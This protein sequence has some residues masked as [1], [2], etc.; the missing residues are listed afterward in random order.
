MPVSAAPVPNSV[1]IDRIALVK[2]ALEERIREYSGLGYRW[3]DMR[4][5]SVD[6][7]FS[8]TV[9]REHTIY[10]NQGSIA[11]TF[12]LTNNRLTFKI[13]PKVLAENPQMQDND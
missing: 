12:T 5:L 11:K 13:P 6:A 1:A 7:E 8:A 3:Y 4:R 10:T 9:K 2:F